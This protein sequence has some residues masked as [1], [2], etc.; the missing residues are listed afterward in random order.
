M[1][2]H[3]LKGA[4]TAQ[5]NQ[6]IVILTTNSV[7][8]NVADFQ[9]PGEV[10]H[11]LQI[12]SLEWTTTGGSITVSRGANVLFVLTEGQHFFDLAGRGAAVGVDANANL[13]ITFAGTGTLILEASKRQL[14]NDY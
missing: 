2:A 8:Y 7:S 13:V 6:N 3:I 5:K 4:N 14:L 9:A 11:G 12:S 1:P 10:V